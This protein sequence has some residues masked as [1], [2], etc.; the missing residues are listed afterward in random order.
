MEAWND[1]LQEFLTDRKV[2]I[3]KGTYDSY[4][5]KFNIIDAW[6]KENNVSIDAW[7]DKTMAKLFNHL[8]TDRGLDKSTC[9]NYRV[10]L[11]VFF[12]FAIKWGYATTK[13]SFSL[14]TFPKKK[15]DKGASVIPQDDF[16]K[17]LR[18]IRKE[19]KQLHLAMMTEYYSALRPGSEIRL[20]RVRE[21]DLKAGVIRI[22]PERAKSR[23]KET[24][25]MPEQL[26][27][28]YSDYLKDAKGGLFVFGKGGK[29]GR[30]PWSEN[31]LRNQFNKY[32][33]KLKLS[34]SYKMYSSK[35]TGITRLAES[36]IPV[37]SIMEHARHTNL[38]VTQA[39]IKRH[40]GLVDDRIRCSFPNP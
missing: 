38:S 27:A 11:S 21:V 1:I 3:S 25:T 12:D 39:Y 29:P 28:L 37:H 16:D 5:S 30:V 20:M 40:G 35:H 15:E 6:V 18:Q 8:I 34:K 26:I 9:K 23:R 17:L 10:A 36:G 33:D 2:A 31:T 32:R 14:V 24:V 4:A 22:P 13:P 19:R 7:D